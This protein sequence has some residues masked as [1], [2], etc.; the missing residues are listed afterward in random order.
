MIRLC[1]HHY[2]SG[3]HSENGDANEHPRC[4]RRIAEADGIHVGSRH[5][6]PAF[7]AVDRHLVRDPR[8][9]IAGDQNRVPPQY[10]GAV[11]DQELLAGREGD[12]SRF[13]DPMPSSASPSEQ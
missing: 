9:G 7:L 5:A 2:V 10:L 8:D 3:N 1:H 4:P 6:T 12:R 11:I 13:R